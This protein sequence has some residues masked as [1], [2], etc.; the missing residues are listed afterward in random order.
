MDRS[1]AEPPAALVLLLAASCGVLAAN[2]YYAQPLIGVI[3]PAVGLS[4]RAASLIMTLFQLGYA[5]GLLLLVPLGDL[6]ENRRPGR[7]CSSLPP[8]R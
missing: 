3:G 1:A 2:I 8:R 7:G 5:A 4:P 6:L